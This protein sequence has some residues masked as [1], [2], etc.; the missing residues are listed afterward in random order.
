VLR[1]SNFTS[2]IWHPAV[3]SLGLSE[4]HFYDLHHA[5]NTLAA[6]TGASLRELMVRMG[7]ASPQAALRYQHATRDRNAAISD[8]RKRSSARAATPSLPSWW[9]GFDSRRPLSVKWLVRR[10]VVGGPT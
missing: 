8:L 2:D 9:C 7:H 1:K 6:A 3:R 5:G 10:F 4:L